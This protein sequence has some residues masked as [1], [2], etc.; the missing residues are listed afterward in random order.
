VTRCSSSQSETSSRETEIYLVRHGQSI[1]NE[2][3]IIAGQL[4]SELTGQGIADAHS[5]ARAIGRNDFDAIYCSDLKRARETA[6]IIVKTLNLTC[7]LSLSP[8]LRELDFGEYTNQPVS[9]AFHFLDYKVVQDRRYP[10]GE[11]FQ[12]MRKR[13]AQF[14]NQLHTEALGKRLLL[15]AHAGSIRMLLIVLDRGHREQYLTQTFSNR[16]LGK[17][18]LGDKGEEF[19]YE[20]IHN[21][22]AESV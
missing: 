1:H 21:H 2:K 18:L 4:D 13:I 19:S 8:L 7:P 9:D 11:S 15:V 16:Y 3:Q 12:D 14:V 5:V 17:V 20:L 22:A 6:E 10:A